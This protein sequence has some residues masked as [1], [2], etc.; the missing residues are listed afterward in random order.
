MGKC[1]GIEIDMQ[2]QDRNVNVSL[3]HLVDIGYTAS[4]KRESVIGQL[5]HAWVIPGQ[6][7]TKNGRP[8]SDFNEIWYILSLPEVIN[9]HPFLASYVIWLLIYNSSK[10]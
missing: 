2:F 7:I 5:S 9:P 3:A 8:P 1:E 6:V 4:T 10:I